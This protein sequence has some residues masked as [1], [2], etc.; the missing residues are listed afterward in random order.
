MRTALRWSVV[1]SLLGLS[2]ALAGATPKVEKIEPKAA[3][4]LAE[5]GAATL[6][7]VREEEEVTS[8]MAKPAKWFPLSKVRSDPAAYKAF[9]AK[10]PKGKLVF[11]CAA[12]K[13][14]GE[15]AEQAA[16][17]G[18][19]VANMGGMEDWEAAGLPTKPKP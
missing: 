10:Q 3:A 14:A 7:D 1:T 12:G 5:K 2:V 15:A 9:L 4:A 8:G 17:L 16:A 6:I 13:R 18:Y 19:P 11:Y